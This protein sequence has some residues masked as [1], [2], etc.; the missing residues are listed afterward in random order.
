MREAPAGNERDW[1]LAVPA[2]LVKQRQVDADARERT[3]QAMHEAATGQHE[4]RMAE[5]DA[6]IAKR[7]SA[8]PGRQVG[9][10]VAPVGGI[11]P[12]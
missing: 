8:S 4:R 12:E 1:H 9:V 6:Q 10:W 5:S 3:H 2:D 7:K 11:P